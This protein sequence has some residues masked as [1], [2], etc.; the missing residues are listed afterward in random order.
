MPSDSVDALQNTLAGSVFA[1]ASD[2]KKAAGRALGTLVEIITYYTLRA[3]DLRDHI[4]IERSLPEFAN[5]RIRHNVEFSLHPIGDREVAPLDA[6]TPPITAAKVRRAMASLG[7][8]DPAVATSTYELLSSSNLIRNSCII[9]EDD[10]GPVVCNVDLSETGRRTV[11]LCHLHSHPFAI[12]EC[13]RVGVEQGMRKG[14]QTIEKAK[15]G[16]YVARS[17]S[18][19]QKKSARGM[20]NY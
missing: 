18:S 10:W 1:Y 9:L 5:D 16:A 11:T 8:F 14:P 15:Q 2:R 7:R 13:K 6:V 4:I 19:L 12:V 20:D 3:W 17:V